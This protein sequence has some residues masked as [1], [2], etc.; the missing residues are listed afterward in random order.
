MGLSVAMENRGFLSPPIAGL[1]YTCCTVPL[2]TSMKK[3]LSPGVM[4][5]VFVPRYCPEL[6]FSESLGAV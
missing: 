1:S 4:A 5:N 6:R 2:G 3:N